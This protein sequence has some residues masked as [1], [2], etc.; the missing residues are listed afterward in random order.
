MHKPEQHGSISNLLGRSCA[1]IVTS[2]PRT[3]LSIA[4]GRRH[5]TRPLSRF[6]Q[7]SSLRCVVLP[8]FEAMTS[9]SVPI[10]QGELLAT[11]SAP[12]SSS[13][14]GVTHRSFQGRHLLLTCCSAWLEKW[15]IT[16]SGGS[17]G[18]PSW[19]AASETMIVA[20]WPCEPVPPGVFA[21]PDE[22]VYLA[23]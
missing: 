7:S 6:H 18:N 11:D 2:R 5:G 3:L 21:D 15:R 13:C 9:S 1:P 19:S 23:G 12:S 4:L 20:L 22:P 8:W 17:A 10:G 16:L 14:P